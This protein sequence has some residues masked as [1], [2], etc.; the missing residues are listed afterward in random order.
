MVRCWSVCRVCV[1]LRLACFVY[2]SSSAARCLVGD[3]LAFGAMSG[4]V[5][6]GVVC[7]ATARPPPARPREQSRHISLHVHERTSPVTSRARTHALYFMRPPTPIVAPGW[8]TA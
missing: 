8:P 5:S 4:R 7:V 6:R 1:L 3:V 2:M